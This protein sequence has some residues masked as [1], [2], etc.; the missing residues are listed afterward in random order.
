MKAGPQRT[1]ASDRGRGRGSASRDARS[2][3]HGSTPGSGLSESTATLLDLQET[4]GNRAVVD[5]LSGADDSAVRPFGGM[6]LQRQPTRPPRGGGAAG[7]AVA[8]GSKPARGETSTSSG[9]ADDLKAA[10]AW[11][12]YIALRGNA[13][14][15]KSAIPTAYRKTLAAIQSA[16]GP[17]P[18]PA[19]ELVVDALA[20]ADARRALSRMKADHDRLTPKAGYDAYDLADIAIE[21][22]QANFK[23]GDNTFEGGASQLD[24]GQVLLSIQSAADDELEAATKAGYRIPKDLAELPSEAQA[25]FDAAKQN[26]KAGAPSSSRLVTPT[27]EMDLIEFI[28]HAVATINSMTSKRAADIARARDKEA[29]ALRA[30]AD[31]QLV[32]LQATLAERRKAAFSA[33]DK[34]TLEK[35][36]EALGSVNGAINEIKDTAAII[37]DRVDQLNAVSEFVS[38]GGKK[39]IELPKVPPAISGIAGK[40]ASAQGKIGKVVEL[41]DLVGPAKTELEGGLKYLKAV[42]MSLEHFGAKSA[43]PFVAVY[44]GSYLSPGIKACMAGIRSIAATISGQNRGLIEAGEGK[45]VNWQVEMG[46]EAV[47]LYMVQ[48]YK[49]GGAASISDAAWEFFS[50]HRGDLSTAV[51]DPMPKGRRTISA[52][53]SKNRKNL[54]ESFYGSVRPPRQ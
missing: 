40:L 26:W 17:G 11:L 8:G 1:P 39:L 41:L 3:A 4:A 50:D 49:V 46:G 33:G 14:Q 7:T 54:W 27:E 5:L 38:K 10:E 48:V 43:N 20:F 12:R 22:G 51:G 35:I 24:V 13:D 6:T 42:D 18:I 15:P 31:K 37:T 34:D 44:V 30:T 52:W 32:E 45:Y 21:R 16:T 2:S 29:D 36:H 25:Q 19:N 9:T 47:F 28:D 23:G 53:A